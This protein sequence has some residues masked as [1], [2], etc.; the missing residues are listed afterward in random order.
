MLTDLM[1][2]DGTGIDLL[3]LAKQ[4]AARTE[5]IVMTAH[6]AVETAIDAMKRGAYDFV[7]KPFATTELRALV[8][9]ALEKR[10]HRRRERAPP[11]AARAR[12]GSARSSATPRRCAAIVDLMQS[13]A[14]ARTT[15]LITG[16]SGTGKERIARAI[17]DASDR[18]D[19]ARSSSSTAARSPRRS[20]RRALRPR[21]GRVHRRR[22]ASRL[23]HLPRGRGR[24][25]APRRGRR[26][27]A[28][29]SR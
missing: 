14:P 13:V 17:H 28:R 10:A 1:M 12:A 4:R 19:Q 7:T 11:R 6:G 24:H 26:A 25:G 16:E 9:K 15:V 3:S 27:A 18:R 23:G 29:R 21:E 8:H 22:V 20:S 5:V 2:P